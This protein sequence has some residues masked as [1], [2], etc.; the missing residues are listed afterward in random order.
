MPNYRRAYVEGGSYF[1]TVVTYQRA[2]ILLTELARTT[3][4]TAIKECQELAP[5]EVD[6]FVLL[7]DHLHTIWTLP[8]GDNNYSFRWSFIKKEFSKRYLAEGGAE[9][10]RSG[11]RLK[12]NERG[13]WQRRFWEHVIRDEKDFERHIDYI[14]YNPVKHGLV[15]CPKDYNYSTFH[16]YAKRGVYPLEWGCQEMPFTD[17]ETT[18]GE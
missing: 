6:A 16:A 11:S 7:N 9:Q 17:I 13:I 8:E 12:Q 2:D 18:V 4:R 14:H 10:K 1:F 5:F 3:L 15:L